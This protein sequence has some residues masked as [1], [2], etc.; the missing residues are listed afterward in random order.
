MSTT[1]AVPVE[2][3]RKRGVSDQGRTR[4]LYAGASLLL[5]ILMLIGFQQFFVHGRAFPDRP[6]TPPI[7]NLI[8]IHGIS[9]TVWMV[10]LV[11]QSLLVARRRTRVHMKLGMFGA[12]VAAV[13]TVSG[14]AV[15]FGS[16]RVSPPEAI[17]WNLSMKHFMIAPLV[18]M[19]VF[20]ATVAIAIIKRKDPATHKPLMFLATLFMMPAPVDRIPAIVSLYQNN[21]LGD[22]LGPFVP[23][24]FIG[25]A[26]LVVK[27]LL[28]R[29]WDRPF[30][31]VWAVMVVVGA[32][33]M[34]VA[35]TP[36]L[37]DPISRALFGQ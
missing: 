4:Y 29:S 5:L 10:L 20:G 12:A 3:T 7:R 9:S 2:R 17:L 31:I 24:L 32:A 21:I 35:R 11:V 16:A 19:L 34:Y 14:I 1:T 13:V 27:W 33:A 36:A 6:L 28:T 37:A 30:A 22:V 25:G 18:I 26:F 23:V 8:L 15:A